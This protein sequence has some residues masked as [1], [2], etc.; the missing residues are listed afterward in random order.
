[1]S[2]E[3]ENLRWSRLGESNPRPA[4]SVTP[5]VQACLCLAYV[6]IRTH[7]TRCNTASRILANTQDNSII[8]GRLAAKLAALS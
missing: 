2:P 4:Q 6:L 5:V 3:G 7:P 1:M 8:V